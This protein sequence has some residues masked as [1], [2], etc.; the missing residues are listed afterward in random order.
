MK[1]ELESETSVTIQT[2]LGDVEYEFFFT[3]AAIAKNFQAVVADQAAAAETE[4]IR[5]VCVSL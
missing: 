3:E 1:A 4:E 2:S 5:K